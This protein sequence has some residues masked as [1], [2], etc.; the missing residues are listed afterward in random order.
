MNSVQLLTVKPAYVA[1]DA[2]ATTPEGYTLSRSDG[3]WVV[4]DSGEDADTQSVESYIRGIIS[5]RANDFTPAL[6]ANDS[7]FTDTGAGRLVLE[8][9]D[10]TRRVVTIGTQIAGKYSAAVSGSQ[11]VYLLMDWQLDQLFKERSSLVKK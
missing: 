8:T 6:G 9:G 1:S 11:Y 2:D 10:G 4:E 5:C 7:V 3:G